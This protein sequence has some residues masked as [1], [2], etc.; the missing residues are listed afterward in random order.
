MC[1]HIFY[2]VTWCQALDRFPVFADRKGTAIAWVQV[3][4]RCG[5]H[6]FW[7]PVTQETGCWIS[8]CS[9]LLLEEPPSCSLSWHQQFV[10]S[11]SGG[12]EPHPKGIL[13]FWLLMV[14][15]VPVEWGKISQRILIKFCTLNHKFVGC[16]NFFSFKSVY[17]YPSS[18]LNWVYCWCLKSLIQS[19]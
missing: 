14:T 9:S 2:L 17:L 7:N 10:C 6:L 18:I 8:R 1:K 16:L 13:V 3:S 12:W 4:L 5:Y 15:L 19:G 11:H